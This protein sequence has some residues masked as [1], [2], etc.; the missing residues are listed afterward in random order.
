M[1]GLVHPFTDAERKTRVEKARELMAT[2]KIDAI[3]LTGGASPQYFAN[4][5]FGGGERLWALVIPSKSSPFFVA[6]AFEADRVREILAGTPLGKDPDIRVFQ[7]DESPYARLIQGLKD[8]GIARGRIGVEET[9]KFVFADGIALAA[10]PSFQVVSATPITAGCRM[11][12]DAHEIECLRIAGQAT[13]RVYEAVL[14][15]VVRRHDPAR[16]ERA[17]SGGLCARR[18]SRR[19]QPQYR[20][21]HGLAAWFA[22]PADDP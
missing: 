9:T 13:V 16:R 1:T 8:R 5:T 3:V 10:K 17:H 22:N 20:G 2:E 15:S 19:S 6:P 4:V 21:I 11:I 18:V 12:K 7:E 14:S